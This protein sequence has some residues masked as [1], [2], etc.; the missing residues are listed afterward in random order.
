LNSICEA[1]VSAS[2]CNDCPYDYYDEN[3]NEPDCPEDTSISEEFFL[4]NQ[5]DTVLTF[6]FVNDD[7]RKLADVFING[8]QFSIDTYDLEYSRNIDNYVEPGS[9]GLTIKPI[10]DSITIVEIKVEI[11]E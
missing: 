6:K 5:Y 7:E 2:E 4:L 9:N 8:R 10:S 3:N 1:G 11:E